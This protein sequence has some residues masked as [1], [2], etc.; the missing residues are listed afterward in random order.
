MYPSIIRA[1][2]LCFSSY[3]P[4]PPAP[5]PHNVAYEQHNGQ[6]F[7][8]A[9]VVKGLLPEVVHHLGECRSKAKAA[10]AVATDPMQKRICKARE[11]A[12]KVRSYFLIIHYC[13]N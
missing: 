9:D 4:A 10:Y 3:L 11:L 12:F 1:H 13:E 7:V 8:T 6:R 2:N 5:P